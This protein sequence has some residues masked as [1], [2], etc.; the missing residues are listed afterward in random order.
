MAVTAGT[1]TCF[2]R[3]AIAKDVENDANTAAVAHA[4]VHVEPVGES[5]GSLRFP[6]PAALAAQLIDGPCTIT[7]SQ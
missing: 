2:I 3:V 4:F 6:V 5:G 7:V 1:L